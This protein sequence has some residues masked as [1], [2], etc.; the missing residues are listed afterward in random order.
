MGDEKRVLLF[1]L[2]SVLY[3]NSEIFDIGMV[4]GDERNILLLLSYY[5]CFWFRFD[6]SIPLAAT[7]I[8]MSS[9]SQVFATSEAVVESVTGF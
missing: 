9:P 5:D 1:T 7:E 2:P 3:E 4:H 6:L 8:P